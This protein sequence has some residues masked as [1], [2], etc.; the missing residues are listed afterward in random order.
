MV[1]FVRLTRAGMDEFS[2]MVEL[3]QL[4]RHTR[5]RLCIN[6]NKNCIVP[7]SH[8][9]YPFRTCSWLGTEDIASLS[10]TLSHVGGGDWD[11]PGLR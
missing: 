10:A 4:M 8:S 3:F 1:I 11:Y 5:F 6:R 9:V 7:R 2:G